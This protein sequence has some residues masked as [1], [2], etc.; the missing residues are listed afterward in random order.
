MH[1]CVSITKKFLQNIVSKPNIAFNAVLKDRL[2]VNLF[3][4][5]LTIAVHDE[6]TVVYTPS[7]KVKPVPPID[8]CRVVTS[9]LCLIQALSTYRRLKKFYVHVED[10]FIVKNKRRY[11][12]QI[13]HMFHVLNWYDIS[14]LRAAICNDKRIIIY[15]QELVILQKITAKVEITLLFF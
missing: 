12:N 7:Y 6:I 4:L 2:G 10:G 9:E 3:P 13:N 14:F 5:L 8:I 11:F 15:S 1:R